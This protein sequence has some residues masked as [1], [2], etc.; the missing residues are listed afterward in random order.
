MQGIACGCVTIEAANKRLDD[1]AA[2]REAARLLFEVD[3]AVEFAVEMAYSLF[4]IGPQGT[5]ETA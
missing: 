2:S 3:V 4:L 1:R 5:T